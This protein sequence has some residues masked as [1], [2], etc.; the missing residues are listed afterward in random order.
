MPVIRRA[1]DTEPVISW[2]ERLSA[3]M[4]A[5]MGSTAGST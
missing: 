5:Q 2:L 1:L 3:E 4:L